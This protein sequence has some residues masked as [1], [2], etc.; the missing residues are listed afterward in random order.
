MAPPHALPHALLVL[1]DGHVGSEWFAEALARQP[2]TRFVFEMGP[3]LSNSLASKMAF[4][5]PARRACACTKEDCVAFR[6]NLGSKAPCL[7]LPS[8]G[9]CRVIG[10]SLMSITSELETRQWEQ[11]LRNHSSMTIVV[12]TRSNLVKWAWSFYRTGAMKRL[13]GRNTPAPSQRESI[14]VHGGSEAAANLSHRARV[15][16]DPVVLLRMIIAK[17]ERSERLLAAARHF[18]RLTSQRRERVLLYESLQ[19]DMA[20]ELRRLYASMRVPFDEGA[21]EQA[22][23]NALLK[24]APDDLSQ[25]ISNWDEVVHAFRAFPCLHAMLTDTTHRPYDDCADGLGFTVPPLTRRDASRKA[26]P[27]VDPTAHC[28]CS[29][30]TP[31]VDPRGDVLDDATAKELWDE[32]HAPTWGSDAAAAGASAL[33]P[34]RNQARGGGDKSAERVALGAASVAA[35]PCV[36]QQRGSGS[37]AALMIA[38]GLI[39]WGLGWRTRR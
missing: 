31:I 30:R 18:A 26:K 34:V 7:D 17:Q 5:G 35:L 33:Q 14:H 25:A 21:H 28:A 23:S 6:S 12:Q 16:V 13:R 38:A 10:G 9:H 20:D 36:A 27:A 11:V 15:Q 2:G 1:K 4:F 39:G 37:T 32:M 22:A 8:R 24:H 29:W 3:C 19:A